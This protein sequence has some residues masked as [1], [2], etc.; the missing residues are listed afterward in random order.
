MTSRIGEHPLSSSP[1]DNCF[2]ASTPS[3]LSHWCTTKGT[4]DV[5][6]NEEYSAIRSIS[7]LDS[8]MDPNEDLESEEHTH[9]SVLRVL[10]VRNPDPPAEI[11]DYESFSE[12]N[13]A[14]AVVVHDEDTKSMLHAPT[15]D[16]L[17]RS[18]QHPEIEQGT[19]RIEER[20]WWS[21]NIPSPVRV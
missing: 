11:S 5:E 12:A 13:S 7:S 4:D 17:Y 6:V 9:I 20:V 18:L 3:Y 1:G 19:A 15:S 2:F 21:E 14:D 16:G 10:T 8:E